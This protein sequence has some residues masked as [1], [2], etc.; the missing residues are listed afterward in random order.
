MITKLIRRRK[1]NLSKKLKKL[2]RQQRRSHHQK[3]IN[4]WMY[5]RHL[6]RPL[7]LFSWMM[8][9]FLQLNKLRQRLRQLSLKLNKFRLHRKL[10][11]LKSLQKF[12]HTLVPGQK[13]GKDLHF[14]WKMK[15]SETNKKRSKNKILFLKPL[16]AI[17][18]HIVQ[19]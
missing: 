7:L 6:F 19:H 8:K 15:F 2:N 13:L 11:N 1:R 16:I 12:K 4:N 18:E 9:T 5:K 14:K 10:P 3:I 17:W